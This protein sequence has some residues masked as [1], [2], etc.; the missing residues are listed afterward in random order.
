MDDGG[1]IELLGDR[2]QQVRSKSLKK[3]LH[4]LKSL[5]SW[6]QQ[7]VCAPHTVAEAAG[8][9][10]LPMLLHDTISLQYNF[11]R[12]IIPSPK[13]YTMIF[14]IPTL[15]SC[16]CSCHMP[17]YKK[18]VS[19]LHWTI[20]IAHNFNCTQFHPA[21]KGRDISGWVQQVKWCSHIGQ[22]MPCWQTVAAGPFWPCFAC[23]KLGDAGK[24]RVA[25]KNKAV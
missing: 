5:K 1:K 2:E 16:H 6:P 17:W 18:Q 13:L 3:S 9:G 24:T 23:P 4:G 10:R 19:V 14:V 8:K 7:L 15:Q 11:V 25:S 20:I 22:Q 12:P 21:R